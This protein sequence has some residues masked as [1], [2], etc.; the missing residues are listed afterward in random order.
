L[1]A[2]AAGASVSR[3]FTVQAFPMD[4]VDSF[5]KHMQPSVTDDPQAISDALVALFEQIGPAILVT[6][7]NAGLYGWL[8]AIR[9]PN[10]KAIVS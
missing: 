4:A 1:V 2:V 6:H 9:W 5:L 3:K 7:S 10:V 8:A